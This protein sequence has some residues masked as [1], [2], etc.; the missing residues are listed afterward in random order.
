MASQSTPWGRDHPLSQGPH[1][2]DLA[3]AWQVPD[4]RSGW[5]GMVDRFFGPG[6]T[7]AEVLVQVICAPVLGALVL[8]QVA[9]A[10]VHLRWWSVVVLAVFTIDV[11]GGVLTNATS[12]AKR[13]YHRPGTRGERLRF[14]C[15]HVVHLGLVAALVLDQWWHWLALNAVL[16][17]GLALLIEHTPLPIRRAV[18]MG[19]LV[20]A[21]LLN[22]ILAPVP[23][24]LAW[25]APLLYLKLLVSHL[26]PEAPFANRE[27]TR[28]PGAGSE[29]ASR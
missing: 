18:A 6:P 13:W 2:P 25:I 22:S 9:L 26:V 20:A 23:D 15:L 29:S 10:E 17:V 21:I 11:L 27:E 3:I 5:R 12:A 28:I 19:A 24:A 4:P 16:L 7:R 14:V 8:A 1:R